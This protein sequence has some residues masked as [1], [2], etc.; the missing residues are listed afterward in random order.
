MY[1]RGNWK[2]RIER[3][4]VPFLVVM[5]HV[6]ELMDPIAVQKNVD[7]STGVLV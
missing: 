4:L 1:C 5:M 7:F 2:P 6:L 3:K